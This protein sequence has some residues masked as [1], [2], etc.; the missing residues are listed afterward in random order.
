MAMI[1]GMTITSINI[2][3]IIQM[4]MY[5]KKELQAAERNMMNT[6][7]KIQI[8]IA[9]IIITINIEATLISTRAIISTTRINKNPQYNK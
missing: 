1:M 6:T 4:L 7:M 8:P 3:M 5:I 2:A 9:I